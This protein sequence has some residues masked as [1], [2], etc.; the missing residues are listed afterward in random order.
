MNFSYGSCVLSSP[1]FKEIV[2][3]KL[4]GVYICLSLSLSLYIFH[5]SYLQ[6]RK[7]RNILCVA[8]NFP[9]F[10]KNRKTRSRT[11]KTRNGTGSV[12]LKK[13]KKK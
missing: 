1:E 7:N 8:L 12:R 13:R 3:E 4:V 2:F 6:N 11:R 9:G 5:A 10:D